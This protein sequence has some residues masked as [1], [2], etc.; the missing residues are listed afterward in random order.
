MNEFTV[1]DLFNGFRYAYGT[2]AG[3]CRWANVDA[4]LVARHLSGEEMIGIYPMVY[5]PHWTRGGPDAWRE[6]A[7][8]RYYVQMEPDLWHCMWGA[9]DI[10]EGDDSIVYARNV[11]TVF[12]A[13]EIKAW[14][15]RSR[16]KGCHIWLFNREWTRASIMR[17]AMKAALDIADIPYDAVYPKQDSLK[18]PP[19]NY[20]RLPYGGDRPEGKQEVIDSNGEP[21]EVDDFMERARAE[22]ILPERLERAAA[23]YKEPEPIHPDLPPRR[24]YS[25]EPLMNL[26]GTRLRGLPAE[27]FNNGPVPYY[28]GHGAGRGRH[29]FLNRF[30]RSMFEAGYAE[31]D[32]TSWTKDLD[33]RLGAWWQDG[34]KFTGRNDC[35]RQIERLVQDA[36]RR[37]NR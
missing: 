2:D 29:G 25:K 37:A 24:D 31:T 14:V 26:D 5:D 7:D 15:E 17:R 19:G 28:R 21:L 35:D 11:A 27:M 33:S 34:P 32:V 30:A 12:E 6:D 1:L 8:D 22:R 9:I 4:D 36:G 18:G 10:D 16:S 23:L 13:L 3:G 20:M